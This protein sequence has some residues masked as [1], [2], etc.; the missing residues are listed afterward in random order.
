MRNNTNARTAPRRDAAEDRSGSGEELA[1]PGNDTASGAAAETAGGEDRQ[2]SSVLTEGHA[3]GAEPEPVRLTGTQVSRHDSLSE[4]LVEGAAHPGLLGSAHEPTVSEAVGPVARESSTRS[5]EDDRMN[6]AGLGGSS[7]M[8]DA[9]EP[10]RKRLRRSQVIMVDD[11]EVSEEDEEEHAVT[12]I[13]GRRDLDSTIQYLVQWEDRTSLWKSADELGNCAEMVAAYDMYIEK[14]P[15]QSTP[16][17]AFV[18]MDMS[19]IKLLGDNHKDDCALHALQMAFELMGGFEET[20]G[21]LKELS[22][23]YLERMVISDSRRQGGLK[24][25]QLTQFLKNEVPR[26]GWRVNKNSFMKNR[27]KGTGTGP[28]GVAQLAWRDQDP[29]EDGVYLVYALKRNQRGHVVA[30]KKSEG[31]MVVREDGVTQ[32]IMTQTWMRTI[33]FVRRIMVELA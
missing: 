28:Y 13:M 12:R 16:Y 25:G 1:L 14:H 2:V 6:A 31:T 27:Y 15:D 20:A 19:S 10:N 9:K 30:M 26:T 33:C 22:E 11:E 18:A 8:D 24:F 32:G 5:G 29:L 3:T 7:S 17:A 21:R 4:S 23:A